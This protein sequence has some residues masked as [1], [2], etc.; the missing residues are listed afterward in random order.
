MCARPC[1]HVGKHNGESHHTSAGNSS[2]FKWLIMSSGIK[3][4]SCLE[5]SFFSSKGLAC[6]AFDH[7]ADSSDGWAN[8]T[9]CLKSEK[10]FYL[11]DEVVLNPFSSRD[12][13]EIFRVSHE[14]F[15]YLCDQLNTTICRQTTRLR[16]PACVCSSE[17]WTYFVD[18]V[19]FMWVSYSCSFIWNSQKYS[20]LDCERYLQSDCKGVI[21]ITLAFLL[22]VN[23]LRR[24]KVLK[25][26]GA[27]PNVLAPLMVCTFLFDPQQWIIQIIIIR[28]VSLFDPW[29]WIIQIIIIRKVST[30]C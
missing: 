9:K 13:L 1:Q 21:Q 25:H 20:L 14:M 15:L 30:Q 22:A 17:S 18:F 27:F 23:W 28:K 8:A 26:D 10:S 12:W 24:W 4:A 19:N 6:F 29:Q 2:F 16:K 5:T 7:C 3:T 11:V